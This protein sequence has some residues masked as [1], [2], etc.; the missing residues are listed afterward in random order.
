SRGDLGFLLYT[1]QQV[2]TYRDLKELGRYGDDEIKHIMAMWAAEIE[3]TL[4]ILPY[5]DSK[6]SEF[7]HYRSRIAEYI[8]ETERQIGYLAESTTIS[9]DEQRERSDVF[10]AELEKYKRVARRLDSLNQP[11]LTEAMRKALFRSRWADE[12]IRVSN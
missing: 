11:T 7:D 1:P 9:P 12:H 2:K 6:I 3:C 8:A 10:I 5:D 4:E